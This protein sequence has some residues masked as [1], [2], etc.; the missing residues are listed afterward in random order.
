[1]QYCAYINLIILLGVKSNE[2]K[3]DIVLHVCDY[4]VI[5]ILNWREDI[6]LLDFFLNVSATIEQGQTYDFHNFMASI[7]VITKI[8][9]KLTT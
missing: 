3:G 6:Q 7:G 9:L 2:K 4:V 8:Q 1:M 5:Q